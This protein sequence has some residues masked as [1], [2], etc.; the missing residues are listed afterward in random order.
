M[1][2]VKILAL[3]FLLKLLPHSKYFAPNYIE[4]PYG[5]SGK[6]KSYFFRKNPY[7]ENK[8]HIKNESPK[9][10]K[11]VKQSMLTISIYY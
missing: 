3:R 9:D 5:M 4:R 11:T 8:Q 2:I 7:Y 6:N 1:I 10:H